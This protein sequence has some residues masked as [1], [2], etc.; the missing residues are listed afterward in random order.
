MRCLVNFKGWRRICSR[1]GRKQHVYLSALG[2]VCVV[3]KQQIIAVKAKL[4]RLSL[5]FA[6]GTHSPAFGN[7]D[8]VLKGKKKKEGESNVTG[9]EVK[10]KEMPTQ[11]PTP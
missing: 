2:I 5:V 1:K 6:D 9:N 11:H 8:A 4:R 3:G 7:K 10:V